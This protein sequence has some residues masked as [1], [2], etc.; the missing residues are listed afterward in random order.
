MASPHFIPHTYCYPYCTILPAEATTINTKIVNYLNFFILFLA[1]DFFYVI[2][3]L[4]DQFYKGG[5][6]MSEKIQWIMN[7][8]TASA[9]K[10][11]AL[12]KQEEVQKV[13]AFHAGFPQYEP[14]PLVNLPRMAGH[15]GIR[16]LCI[17]D[18]SWR[19]GL[20]AFKVLG[21]SYAM[22]R[23]IAEELGHPEEPLPY[24]ELT[25]PELHQKFG[26][27]VFFSATDGNHGRGV[28]WSAR[29][30]GQKAVIF[31]PKGTTNARLKNIQAEAAEVT[32]EDMNYDACVRLAAEE[33]AK[34]P[35]GVVIQDTA[36]KG[37]E[38]IPSWIMQ[39]Y[40]TMVDEA[41]EACSAPPTHVFVQ[42]GVGSLAGAVTG[43]IANRFSPAPPRIIVVEAEA[44]ACLYRSAAAGDGQPGDAA[45]AAPP[46][47]R[48]GCVVGYL[49]L[50]GALRHGD[51]GVS[52]VQTACDAAHT[53]GAANGDRAGVD[54]AHQRRGGCDAA[55]DTAC[56]A[57]S[58]A[59]RMAAARRQRHGEA[60]LAAAVRQ[61]MLAVTGKASGNTAQRRRAAGI[62]V[63]QGDGDIHL[64]GAALHGRAAAGTAQPMGPRLAAV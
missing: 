37:Y 33:A 4:T 56:A 59:A 16:E 64:C 48:G 36:W 18:E 30:L 25:S 1:K 13:R 19:F 35:H 49:P 38:K 55:C 15:L 23:Y 2:V 9:D 6:P 28:A 62:G 57:L 45:G 14:T 47:Q 22:S 51:S 52:P 5:Y 40:S 44:A 61:T 27:A 26:Q 42:A 34:V 39:G 24:A 12:L 20:N 41:V 43:Y 58:A 63:R 8:M 21:G 29:Q 32:I 10:H 53:G 50:I 7:T 3:K 11:L 46:E 54:A 31:M 17:K 60:A